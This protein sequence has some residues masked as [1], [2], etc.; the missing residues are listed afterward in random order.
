MQLLGELQPEL[1]PT[2]RKG[3][4]SD[5]S[6]K[7]FYGIRYAEPPT[8]DLR[9]RP[10]IPKDPA[11]AAHG[12]VDTT[13]R[14]PV[15]LQS[16]LSWFPLETESATSEESEDCLL[17][18]VQVPVQ[19]QSSKLPVLVNIHGG[20]IAALSMQR[21]LAAPR[22]ANKACTRIYRWPSRRRRQHCSPRPGPT[23]SCRNPIST[24][25]LRI[26]GWSCRC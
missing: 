23:G 16:V 26:P 24:R 17:L 3:L 15:C 1:L 4:T 14:G 21:V 19:P 7:S 10:P 8:K 9:W 6:V 18:D 2:R 22:C 11:Q 12:V 20:G 25:R 5:D 13:A